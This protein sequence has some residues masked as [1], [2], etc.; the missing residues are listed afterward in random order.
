VADRVVQAA[1]KLVLEPVFEA[2]FQP[3]S[4]GF[5]PGRRAHDAIA[6]I[7]LSATQR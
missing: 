4:Y 6:E 7:Q 5:P 1:L 2:G 3:C